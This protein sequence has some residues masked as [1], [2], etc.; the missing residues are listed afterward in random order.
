MLTRLRIRNFKQFDDVD[1]ELAKAVV[2]IG[3]NNSGKTTAFNRS[4]YGRL[5]FDGGTKNAW[6]SL[7]QRNAQEL[8]LTVET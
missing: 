8:R 2:L 6:A 5:A 7:P 3:P 4:H 1:I